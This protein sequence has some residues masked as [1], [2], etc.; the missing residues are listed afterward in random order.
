MTVTD[1]WSI[2]GNPNG[3]YLMAL[4]TGAMLARSENMKTPIITANYISRC[5]PG[6]AEIRI[7]E[8]SL[9]KQFHRFEARLIQ[10]GKEKVRALATFA[11][12][13]TEC[14][15]NRYETAA[16]PLAARESCVLIPS[17]P[18]YTLFDQL[19]VRLDPACAG[20]M[21]NRL[22]DKSENKGW[23][24]FKNGSPYDLLS[25]LLISDSLPPA[26]MAT[27][28]MMAWVP[29]I[30]LSVSIRNLPQSVWLNCCLR[31]RFITCGLLEADGEVWDEAGNLVAISRQIAQVKNL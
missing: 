15:I 25:V 21:Q 8:I 31:T 20:W 7:E 19:D 14:V 5:T 13:N 4:M 6:S 9:T 18:T 23:I 17:I 10:G 1:N 2:N 22:T 28:G 3:G 16:T 12:E 29:T 11:R 26:V 27:H 24:R 30:E